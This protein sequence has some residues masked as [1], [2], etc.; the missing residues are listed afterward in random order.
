[1]LHNTADP[2]PVGYAAKGKLEAF[3]ELK[4]RYTGCIHPLIFVY[5]LMTTTLSAQINSHLLLCCTS[6]LSLK[7]FVYADTI[8]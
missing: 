5:K 1:M 2:C 4:S 7:I 8:G 3:L 6:G